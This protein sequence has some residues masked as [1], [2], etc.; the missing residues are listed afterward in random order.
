MIDLSFVK[1]LLIERIS[2]HELSVHG[3]YTSHVLE[4]IVEELGHG[5][6][7]KG[8][9]TYFAEVNNAKFEATIFTF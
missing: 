1:D 9:V 3:T 6:A 2:E 7:R 4:Q 5:D 8:T